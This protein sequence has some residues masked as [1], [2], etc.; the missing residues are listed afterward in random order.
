MKALSLGVGLIRFGLG[1][2]RFCRDVETLP[3]ALE[4]VRARLR[5]RERILLGVLQRTVFD[6]P[7][8][9]YSVL[10][11]AAGCTPDDVKRLVLA[12]GVESALEILRRAGVYVTFEEF[13][14]L[15]PAIRGSQRFQFQ[16]RDF[17]N[18]LL[19]PHLTTMSGG[20]RARPTRIIIDL[21]YLA[22]TGP[23]WALWFEAHDWL[24]RSLTFV[25]P[26]HPGVV[27]RQLRCAR[28]GKP[29]DQWFVTARG[30]SRA[31]GAV[32]AFIHLMARRASGS[33]RPS[34]AALERLEPVVE[35]LADQAERGQPPCVVAPP[36][37]AAR[38]S[39]LATRLG[40]SLAGVA[41]SLGGEPYTDARR[42]SIERAGARGVPFYGCSEAAPVGVQ[43]PLPA[44]TDAVHVLTDVYTV[45]PDR[46]PLPDGRHVDAVLLTGLLSAAP[47]IMLNTDIG[48][49][50]R[51]EHRP[52]DC[53]LGRLG[54]ETH[55]SEIRSFQ[56][57]TGDGVTFLGPDLFPLLE[58]V[59]PRRF[60]GGPGDYQLLERQDAAGV[61][62]YHLLVS[63]SIGPVV[64]SE[65]V[66][67]FFDGL[68]SLRPA[69]GFMVDQW[70]RGDFLEVRREPPRVS[71]RGKIPPV[72]TLADRGQTLT[73]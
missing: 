72:Q 33:P 64:E 34:M 20:S 22:E 69:Y 44:A 50:G 26:H 29:Y 45:L 56:K 67:T 25:T 54:Y 9:P 48:D 70:R 17:D 60:G 18:P 63:P 43:C 28:I 58:D 15:A 3:H 27:N 35:A 39:V 13:K 42:H 51:I 10:L 40:R 31:F 1:V 4:T 8:S 62:R 49:V 59:L 37:T 61:S 6:R 68:A 57:L 38:L 2:R 46:R 16:P 23:H 36:T 65:L 30:G 32:S 21:D 14:G 5:D 11:R 73:S 47:K 24:R 52:C 66:R 19:I 71:A 7:R 12:D 55:L 41:F 53:R